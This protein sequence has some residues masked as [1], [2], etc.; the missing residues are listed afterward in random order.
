M[1]KTEYSE[2]AEDVSEKIRILDQMEGMRKERKTLIHGQSADKRRRK[3]RESY[4]KY[5]QFPRGFIRPWFFLRAERICA[6]GKCQRFCG[7]D[8]ELRNMK[9]LAEKRKKYYRWVI[10]RPRFLNT[11][12]SGKALL[13][14]SS[15]V[16]TITTK[17]KFEHNENK[18]YDK[19]V[20]QKHGKLERKHFRQRHVSRNYGKHQREFCSQVQG[21][22]PLNAA[23]GEAEP[24]CSTR[25][26]SLGQ[27]IQG[28]HALVQKFIGSEVYWH[29]SSVKPAAMIPRI[30]T[31]FAKVPIT[32]IANASTHDKVETRV[33]VDSRDSRSETC[34]VKILQLNMECSAIVTGEEP[35]IQ[36]QGEVCF[37][38]IGLGIETRS[39]VI[40]DQKP[41][42]AVAVT[43]RY[44]YIVH[45]A[46]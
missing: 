38:F 15:V 10:W 24:S 35:Y 5:S 46:A 32:V 14:K 11:K 33:D 6:P 17:R 44:S 25:W 9:D 7:W 26:R 31:V 16:G 43:N 37:S 21:G 13:A 29:Q 22:P 34:R 39:A 19:W 18:I 20:S 45:L 8:Q 23:K 2:Y 41:C 36:K 4:A 40:C 1:S 42:S 27:A 3:R 12:K 28:S 30:N